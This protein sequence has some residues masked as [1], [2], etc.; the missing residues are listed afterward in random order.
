MP[1]IYAKNGVSWHQSSVDWNHSLQRFFIEFSRTII[2]LV[3]LLWFIETEFAYLVVV[4]AINRTVLESNPLFLAQSPKMVT[5]IFIN[6]W[7]H[8]QTTIR[9]LSRTQWKGKVVVCTKIKSAWLAYNR[10]VKK[11]PQN[12]IGFKFACPIHH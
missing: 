5:E 8:S 3:K 1:F 4:L 7:K 10:N 12:M 2:S 9:L 11:E 6:V